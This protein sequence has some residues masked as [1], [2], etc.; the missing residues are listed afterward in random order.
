MKRVCVE[1]GSGV[2]LDGRDEVGTVYH[3]VMI[4]S[5]LTSIMVSLWA[6]SLSVLTFEGGWDVGGV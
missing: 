3:L 2:E 6:L 5:E 4:L 1:D